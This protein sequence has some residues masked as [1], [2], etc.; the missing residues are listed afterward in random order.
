MNNDAP[1]HQ[2]V[3]VKALLVPTGI[4]RRQ[5]M[6]L[7]GS[8][9][10]CT[11]ILKA[12]CTGSWHQVCPVVLTP[13]GNLHKPLGGVSCIGNLELAYGRFNFKE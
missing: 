9:L 10:G 6:V 4:V 1:E 11:H 13:C 5:E 3:R 2:R 8:N 12:H 7:L